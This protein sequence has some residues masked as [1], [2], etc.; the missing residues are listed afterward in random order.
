VIEF[1]ISSFCTGGGCVEVG[2]TP[3]GVV[4]RDAKD[5]TRQITLTFG[6]SA[7]RSF[8]TAVRSGELGGS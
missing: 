7:W 6:D 2:Q 8:L 1:K 4:V 5:P 3:E